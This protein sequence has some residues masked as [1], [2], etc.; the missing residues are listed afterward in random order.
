MEQDKENEK[1]S[2]SE[3]FI[4]V[5]TILTIIIGVITAGILIFLVLYN[6]PISFKPL[7]YELFINDIANIEKMEINPTVKEAAIRS[8]ETIIKVTLKT[9]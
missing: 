3:A 8:M 1:I 2:I 5:F 9:S 4:A 6:I 7:L